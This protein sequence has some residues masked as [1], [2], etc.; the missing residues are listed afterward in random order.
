VPDAI[1]F[2]Q[3][4]CSGITPVGVNANTTF[5]ECGSILTRTWFSTDACGNEHSESQTITFVDTQA[6]VL[7]N[8]PENITIACG[9][10]LPAIDN[11]Q[12][13]DACQGNVPVVVTETFVGISNCPT[14]RR[15]YCATD[16][17][18]NQT[19]HTQTISFST[20]SGTQALF[21]LTNNGQAGMSQLRFAAS[22]DGNVLFEVRNA[23]GQLVDKFNRNDC[24]AGSL[25]TVEMETEKYASGMYTIT[26]ISSSEML[27]QRLLVVR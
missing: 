22:T 12:A 2:A 21:A 11:V 4:N 27:V 18:G 8:I 13:T 10:E 6:P 1:V 3:D 19:C 7:S 24:A 17:A 23:N 15:Q 9:S 16:C 26:M 25:Y 5:T 14:L 20:P